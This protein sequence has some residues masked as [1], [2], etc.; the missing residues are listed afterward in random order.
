M[1]ID[2]QKEY[3]KED[4]QYYLNK[5]N[6]WIVKPASM[7]RGRGIKTFNDLNYIFDYIIGK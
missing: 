1:A 4:P 5:Q 7:S 3:L 6:I 2:I